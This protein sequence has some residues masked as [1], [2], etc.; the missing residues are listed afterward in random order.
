[1]K[2][3]NSFLAIIVFWSMVITPSISQNTLEKTLVKS[4]SLNGKT[5]IKVDL[6]SVA[7]VKIWN[8]PTARIEMVV[9]V[10]NMSEAML[11]SLIVAGR[12][13]VNSQ[14]E[15]NQMLLNAPAMQRTIKLNNG[16]EIKENVR[17]TLYVPNDVA[18]AQTGS[19]KQ[20]GAQ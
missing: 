2:T 19:A 12:Y 18:I 20:N 3:L 17:Y 8:E 14:Y 7:D 9:A 13:N 1:M 5:I 6:P 16:Q 10:E 15:P 4:F 11:K